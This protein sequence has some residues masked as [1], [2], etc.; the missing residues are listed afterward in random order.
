MNLRVLLVDDDPLVLRA[1]EQ[2][3]TRAGLEVFAAKSRLDAVAVVKGGGPDVALVDHDLG[4]ESG[5]DLLAELRDRWPHCARILWTATDDVALLMDAVNRAEIARV[6]RRP[7]EPEA[8]VE[9]VLGAAAATRTRDRN[10]TTRL[11]EGAMVERRAVDECVRRKQFALAVQ[12]IV[13]VDD[14]RASVIAY[15]ALLR[16]AHPEFKH[17][18]ELLDA[19]ERTGKLGDLGRAVMARAADWL[20]RLPEP[21]LLFV[22]IHPAQ[23]GDLEALTDAVGP[24]RPYA[25]RVV[26][27]ITERAPTQ[28]ITGWEDAVAWLQ[29]E[30]FSLAVDDLGA[31]YNSLTMLAE[32]APQYVKID[33]DLVRGIDRDARKQRLVH[34]LTTFAD[35]TGSNTIAEGVETAAESSMLQQLGVRLLQGHRYGRPAEKLLSEE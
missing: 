11:I 10:A 3:L 24:L 4:G 32:L 16:P 12:P 26:F 35:A 25:P 27:E 15:E 9:L 30:G 21:V 18:G 20:K 33:M 23:L 34:L 1:A 17:A 6:L 13:R 29:G 19:A 7:S 2:T 31:G 22:N 8:L 28:E 5:V 14:D